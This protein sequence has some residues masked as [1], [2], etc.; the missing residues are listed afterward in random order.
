MCCKSASDAVIDTQFELAL[1]RKLEEAK[2]LENPIWNNLWR[3][4]AEE[5][6]EE[7]DPS[8]AGFGWT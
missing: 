5:E 4:L 2:E 6:E 7:E 3:S 8:L 1:P